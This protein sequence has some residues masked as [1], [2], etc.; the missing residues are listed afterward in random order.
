MTIH[1]ELR[2]LVDDILL[3]FEDIDVK[4]LHE[5]IQTEGYE[6]GLDELGLT[7]NQA[8]AIA[9]N[10]HARAHSILSRSN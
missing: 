1:D 2:D 8:E 5:T 10:W 3:F 7:E 9:R 6:A 4:E